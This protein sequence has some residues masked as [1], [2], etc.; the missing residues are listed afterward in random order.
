G[1]L[2]AKCSSCLSCRAPSLIERVSRAVVCSRS[3]GIALG[4]ARNNLGELLSGVLR[5]HFAL[6]AFKAS[7]QDF[8]HHKLGVSFP[9]GFARTTAAANFVSTNGHAHAL[10]G[11]EPPRRA[12][13]CHPRDLAVRKLSN[14]SG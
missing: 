8:R 1:S 6:D 3:C 5:K 14:E 12:V 11:V 4:L 9:I 10:S 13:A 2:R 7:S